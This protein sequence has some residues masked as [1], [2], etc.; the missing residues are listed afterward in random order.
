MES[1]VVPVLFLALA[2]VSL[3]KLIHLEFSEIL[4]KQTPLPFLRVLIFLSFIFGTAF[5]KNLSSPVTVILVYANFLLAYTDT[6]Y[7]LLSPS[8]LYGQFLL[9]W[10]ITLISPADH[11]FFW[12][13]SICFYLSFRFLTHIVPDG[14]GEGDIKLLCVWSCFIDFISM[15]QIIFLATIL[16]LIYVLL[17]NLLKKEVTRLP[18]VPFL[19]VGLVWV[20]ML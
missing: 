19:Y 14:F 10:T 20:L 2:S 6:H 3:P 1:L 13:A 7:T 12:W 8:I 5:Q 11:S 9:M 17:L 4:P 15:W 18:F 16:A